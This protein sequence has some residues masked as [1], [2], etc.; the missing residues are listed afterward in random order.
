MKPQF[1]NYMENKTKK[2]HY[3]SKFNDFQEAKI[4]H[5]TFILQIYFIIHG[6]TK[7]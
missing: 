2:E 7:Y 5:F 1:L 4:S 6:T 3:I